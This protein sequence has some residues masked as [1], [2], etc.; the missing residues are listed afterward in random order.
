MAK[1]DEI[2]VIAFNIWVQEGCC[3]GRDIENWL[4]AEVIWQGN[5]KKAT[6]PPAKGSRG[7]A[8]KKGTKKRIIKKQ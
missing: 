8:T 7:Q 4:R 3:D 2:R 1:E 5:Q 6:N